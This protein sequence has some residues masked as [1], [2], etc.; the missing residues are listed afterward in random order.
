M[1]KKTSDLVPYWLLEAVRLKESQWGPIE[2]AVEVRRTIA[3]G[4]SL[5]Q[6]LLMRAQLLSQRE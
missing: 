2:D 5:E 3:A 1:W 6:R 4:G